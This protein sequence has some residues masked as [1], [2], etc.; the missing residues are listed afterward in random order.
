MSQ[1]T[2]DGHAGIIVAVEQIFII[3]RET[4][5]N[6]E[7]IKG[8]FKVSLYV[9]IPN[10]DYCLDRIACQLLIAMFPV[11]ILLICLVGLWEVTL[12]WGSQWPSGQKTKNTVI[13]ISYIRLPPFN[14]LMLALRQPINWQKSTFIPYWF[15]VN[16]ITILKKK[17]ITFILGHFWP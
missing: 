1:P 5:Q 17:S 6:I 4:V 2:G 8:Q 9:G 7:F 16:L 15:Q 10:V 3:S 13:N 11:Q 12:L 14:G